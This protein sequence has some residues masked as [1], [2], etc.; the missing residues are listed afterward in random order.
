MV[1]GRIRL[2]IRIFNLAENKLNVIVYITFKWTL[3]ILIN[4]MLSSFKRLLT[5]YFANIKMRLNATS[6]IKRFKTNC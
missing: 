6:F 2:N 4:L 1:L 3:I 5:R